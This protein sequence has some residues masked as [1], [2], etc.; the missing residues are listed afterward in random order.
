MTKRPRRAVRAALLSL[1]LAAATL[2]VLPDSAE[3]H[4]LKLFVAV[5]DGGIGGYAFFI[6]GGRPEGADFF[7]KDATGVEAF[8]GK[9]DDRGGFHWRPS[10]AADYTVSVD[11]GD[12]HWAQEKIDADRLA[13][14][15]SGIPPVATKPSTEESAGGEAKTP[16][17]ATPIQPGDASFAAPVTVCPTL[18]DPA[19]L[20]RQVERAVDAA[21]ARRLRP[22]MEAYDLA[23]GRIRFND[24]MGGIGMIVGLA[25][26]GAWATTRRRRG[27]EPERAP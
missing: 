24:I 12:G 25:G 10:V 22:L 11:T 26:A 6:G 27:N 14:V 8:H 17:A 3:A 9:T 20:A 23:E 19:T 4:R 21:L 18:P 13:E 2:A 16:E 7:V 15:G 1:S 5:E